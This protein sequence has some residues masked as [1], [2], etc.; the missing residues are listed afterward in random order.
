MVEKQT[1][2]RGLSGT[3]RIKSTTDSGVDE[4]WVVH[5]TVVD[6]EI[7]IHPDEVP[8]LVAMLEAFRSHCVEN[9]DLLLEQ[10]DDTYKSLSGSALTQ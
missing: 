3:I 5:D 10:A 4:R 2:V 9:E 6:E 8:E 1:I 7:P